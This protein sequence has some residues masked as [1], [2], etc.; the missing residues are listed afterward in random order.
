VPQFRVCHCRPL[1][2]RVRLTPQPDRLDLPRVLQ[3]RRAFPL[4]ALGDLASA[5]LVANAFHLMLDG[6]SVLA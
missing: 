4:T 2:D 3:T 5:A 6:P 1:R